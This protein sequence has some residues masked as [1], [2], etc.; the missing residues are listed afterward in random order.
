MALAAEMPLLLTQP[1][2]ARW[3]SGFVQAAVAGLSPS[4]LPCQAR[5]QHLNFAAAA[6]HPQSRLSRTSPVHF[7]AERKARS[8]A[9]FCHTQLSLPS[10]FRLLS[11]KSTRRRARSA[12]KGRP[13][14]PPFYLRR[15]SPLLA[16]AAAATDKETG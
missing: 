4:A 5:D 7:L 12:K 10:A 3:K 1:A 8:A 15:R 2:P 13:M 11:Q 16:L 6:G 14:K 9:R